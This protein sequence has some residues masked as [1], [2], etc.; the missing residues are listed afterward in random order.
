M[1]SQDRFTRQI[2]VYHTGTRSV[3]N[4]AEFGLLLY[5]P[6]EVY[7]EFALESSDVIFCEGKLKKYI[8]TYAFL[9]I[10]K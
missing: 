7:I 6:L 10:Y 4:R 2:N 1:I 5:L 3:N 9:V 8:V